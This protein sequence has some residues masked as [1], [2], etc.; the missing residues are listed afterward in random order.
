MPAFI[1]F[2]AYQFTPLEA[3]PALKERLLAFTKTR[4]LRG[5]ILLSAEGINF[6][7]AGLREPMDEL[8][9]ELRAV[10]GL[11]NL[12]PKESLSDEQPFNRMLVKIK[13]EIIA[14]EIG[15]A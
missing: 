5:T 1:N 8:L 10:P 4:E 6:F 14:F 11:A 13:K 9:I 3:L 15:R 2:S 7:V 12:T